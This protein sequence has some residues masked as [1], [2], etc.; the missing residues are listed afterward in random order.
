MHISNVSGH[1]Q[2]T[3]AIECALKSIESNTETLSINCFNY[4]N[5]LAEKIVDVVYM[6]IIK[7]MPAIWRFLYDNPKVVSITN[8][9]KRV[10]HYINA[11]K[12]KRL[13]EQ[14]KPDTIICTQA[15]PCGMVADFKRIC[16]I[17]VPLIGVVTDYIPHSLWVYPDVNYY[18]VDSNDA[19]E[20]LVQKG[21]PGDKIKCFGIPIDLKFGNNL[22]RDSIFRKL[23][24]DSSA[25]V[26]LI[27]GGGQGLGPIKEIVLGLDKMGKELQLIVISGTNNKLFNWF[28]KRK[29]T[30]NK[31]VRCFKYIDNIDEL[32]HVSSII[33]TKP[34]GLTTAEA[35]VKGLPMIIVKPIPGQEENNTQFLLNN[36][37]AVRID[38]LKALSSLIESLFSDNNRLDLMRRSASRLGK[39]D[40]SMDIAKLTLEISGGYV[41]K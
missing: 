10:P 21:V 9:L 7:K 22:D 12:I 25:P 36:N 5:P 33:I 26:V 28:T 6:G 17:S 20:R 30:F 18:I 16:N 24:L 11:K 8:R 3:Y 41:S 15:F 35:M 23:K 38:N 29:P 31:T 4:T 1:F 37:A 19:K 39:P 2:A 40:A 13:Y 32:M 27:M 14:F 34:G